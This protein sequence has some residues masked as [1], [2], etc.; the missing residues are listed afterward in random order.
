MVKIKRKPI[1]NR[2]GVSRTIGSNYGKGPSSSFS[3][4]R[5]VSPWMAYMKKYTK[6]GHFKPLKVWPSRKAFSKN[7]VGKLSKFV[8]NKKRNPMYRKYSR[9][10]Y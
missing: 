5:Q 9:G 1:K 10:G 2:Q 4:K 6:L 7:K 3:R 8:A